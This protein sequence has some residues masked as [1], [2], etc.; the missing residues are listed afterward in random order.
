MFASQIQYPDNHW[1][2]FGDAVDTFYRRT[3]CRSW[4]Y[5][6]CL[7]TCTVCLERRIRFHYQQGDVDFVCNDCTYSSTWMRYRCLVVNK[8][9]HV[10][11][12][13][14]VR[15]NLAVERSL[16]E[17]IDGHLFR[18]GSYHLTDSQ[19]WY[20]CLHHERTGRILVRM[21]LGGGTEQRW[22]WRKLVK[23]VWGIHILTRHLCQ[24]VTGVV[25]QYLDPY[26][27]ICPPQ[28]LPAQP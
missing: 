8:R 1:S 26:H 16:Y 2:Y 10:S 9:I 18:H 21:M 4:Q 28:V 12:L 3:W 25:K 17:I 24:D 7:S 27:S 13:D 20:R 6:H 22:R 19:R 11:C 23:R 5:E 14:C 15:V